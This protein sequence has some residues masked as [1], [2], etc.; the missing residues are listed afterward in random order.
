MVDRWVTVELN[1]ETVIDH[2]R[3][4]LRRP[5]LVTDLPGGASRLVQRADGYLATVKSGQVTFDHGADTGAPGFART[6]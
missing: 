3:L 2:E 4:A 6:V 5:E 1:G